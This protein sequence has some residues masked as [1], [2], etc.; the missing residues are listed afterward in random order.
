MENNLIKKEYNIEDVALATFLFVVL[1]IAFEGFIAFLPKSWLSNTIGLG[2][3]Q[4]LLEAVFAVVAYIIARNNKINVFE[5]TGMKHK[6]NLK[7]VGISLL[8]S[9]V[10]LVLFGDLTNIFLSFLEILGYKSSSSAIVIDSFGKYLIY[11]ICLCIAPA[12]F[13]EMLFRGTILKGLKQYGLKVAIIGSAAIFMIMHG[14]PDQTIHQFIIGMI[15]GYIFYKTGNLWIGIIVHFFNN[16]ISITELYILTMIQQANPIE[17]TVEQVGAGANIISL[18]LGLTF[19]ITFAVVGYMIVVALLRLILKEDKAL[20]QT[21][22][23]ESVIS[24]DGEEQIIELSVN[25]QEMSK[26]EQNDKISETNEKI[27]MS[28]TSRILFWISGIL[29]VGMWLLAFISGFVR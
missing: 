5:A 11:V 13:E 25:G 17:E 20:N 23:G 8:I 26:T 4:F 19:A 3:F 2:F 10:S 22:T 12:I 9:I 18:I 7:L 16:F 1:T 27:E 6:I 24:V 15:I 28:Q 14:S 29:L 21:K